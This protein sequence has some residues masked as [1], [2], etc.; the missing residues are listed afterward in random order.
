MLKLRT[1][2]ISAVF[3]GAFCLTQ[4]LSAGSAAAA[5]NAGSATELNVEPA[6]AAVMGSTG[7]TTFC[8]ASYGG[9]LTDEVHEQRYLRYL[10]KDFAAESLPEWEKAFAERCQAAERLNSMAPQQTELL[11]GMIM[12]CTIA[13][14]DADSDLSELSVVADAADPN[15][16]IVSAQPSEELQ[17][18][19]AAEEAFAAAVEKDDASAIKK[20]LPQIL[21]FYRSDT[22]NMN[23]I[24]ISYK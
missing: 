12:T 10:V 23:N 24:E 11:N 1:T 19:F 7:E 21:E 18:R 13:S 14:S 15:S 3:A 22:D 17:A 16:D 9:L 5:T 6:P 8:C 2:A 20:L 4:V